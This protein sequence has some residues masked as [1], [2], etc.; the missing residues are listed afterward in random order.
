M[1]WNIGRRRFRG[2]MFAWN[3]PNIRHRR[4]AFFSRV[5]K[6]LAIFSPA[7]ETEA[8]LHRFQLARLNPGS[9]GLNGDEEP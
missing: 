4:H 2:A 3:L 1:R 9:I 5:M 7:R 8:T 6:L